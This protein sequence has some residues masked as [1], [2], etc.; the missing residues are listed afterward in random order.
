MKPEDFEKKIYPMSIQIDALGKRLNNEEMLAL[1]ASFDA[2]SE[3]SKDVLMSPE[4]SQKIELLQKE[5]ALSD[6]HIEIVSAIIREYFVFKKDA[7]WLENALMAKLDRKDVEFV[8]EY[9]QKNILTI[10]PAPKVLEEDVAIQ[11]VKTLDLPLLDALSKYQRLSEQTVTEDRI[12]VKGEGQPVRGSIRNWLRHYRD[13]LGIRKH[14]SIERGQ[15]LF[16]GDNTKRLDGVDR[17]KLSLLFRSLDENTPISIDVERQEVIFPSFEEHNE[18]T[19]S[20]LEISATQETP[21]LGTSFR[22]LEKF[23]VSP[24]PI[25]KAL[26]WDSRII[27]SGVTPSKES[28]VPSATKELPSNTKEEK[29]VQRENEAEK[30]KAPG[31]SAPVYGHLPASFLTATPTPSNQAPSILQK[32]TSQEPSLGEKREK[33]LPQKTVSAPSPFA[34]KSFS[35]RAPIPPSNGKISF[36]S[37]HILPNEKAGMKQETPPSQET[38]EKKATQKP[39]A[40]SIRPQSPKTPETPPAPQAISVIKPRGDHFGFRGASPGN[41]DGFD[42]PRVV[43]LRSQKN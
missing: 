42:T 12:A 43:D 27:P 1:W 18:K 39:P 35:P 33:V 10:K 19:P 40:E 24:A 34:E 37:S 6:D 9:I 5:R 17:E 20:P 38:H 13:V 16:Q 26:E 28:Q 14:S 23:P 25:R 8:K 15:F 2:L 11:S 3:E 4:M 31:L 7:P 21:T 30:G 41:E 32:N 36:S 29:P 22:P